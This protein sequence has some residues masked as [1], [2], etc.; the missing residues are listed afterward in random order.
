MAFQIN[1]ARKDETTLAVKINTLSPGYPI[2]A[3]WKLISSSGWE[4]GGVGGGREGGGGY[5]WVYCRQ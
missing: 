4:F 5:T 1:S 3:L 2:A